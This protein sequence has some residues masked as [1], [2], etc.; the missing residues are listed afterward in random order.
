[1]SIFVNKE[2][3][4]LI[5]PLSEE[6]YAQL[7]ANIVAEGVRDPLVVWKQPDGREM[8]I[9]G[10]NRWSIIARHGGIPFEVVYKDF[11]NLE[12]AKIWIMKNQLGRR[13]LNTFER[14]ELALMLK[15][16]IAKRAKANQV[17]TAENRASQKS[18]EQKVSTKDELAKLAG[19]SHDTIH[20][21]EVIKKQ[22]T[23][24]LIEDV[25][26][27]D[28]TINKAY[29]IATGQTSKSPQKAMKELLQKK[30]E[31]HKQFLEKKDDKVVYLAD[32]I[33]DNERME[34]LASKFYVEW[35]SMDK[36]AFNILFSINEKIDFKG[37][38]KALSDSQKKEMLQAITSTRQLAD[39]L[40][41]RLLS[42]E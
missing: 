17:R 16:E 28:T 13:N 14:S 8:L 33:E 9:D 10:H 7:E 6:E 5:P 26:N 15:D 41:G 30:E 2:L 35:L 36:I 42:G 27:G 31:E 18:D 25:R 1:M 11:E 19:V 12:E 3:R 39:E 4:D 37:I 34:L 21:V 24:A 38:M 40:E 20:K 22:G 23:P 29:Q 32:I